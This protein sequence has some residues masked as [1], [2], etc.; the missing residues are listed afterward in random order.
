MSRDLVTATQSA[1]RTVSTRF[2]EPINSVDK[3]RSPIGR[4]RAA[5]TRVR[6]VH[7]YSGLTSLMELITLNQSAPVLPSTRLEMNSTR[8]SPRRQEKHGIILIGM[9]R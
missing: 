5:T 7:T 2:R 1:H 9:I 8:P 3:D 4:T 6:G